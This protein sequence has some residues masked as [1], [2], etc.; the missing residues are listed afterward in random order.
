MKS[1]IKVKIAFNTLTNRK[2][3]NRKGLCINNDSLIKEIEDFKCYCENCEMI[4]VCKG[5]FE[6]YNEKKY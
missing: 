6:K 3:S 2:S 1:Y 4:K 5:L